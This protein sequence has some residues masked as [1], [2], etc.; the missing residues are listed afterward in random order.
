[1]HEDSMRFYDALPK[2]KAELVDG[3]MY[4]GGSLTKSVMALGYMVEQLGVL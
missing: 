3:Q 1:M 4:L 2:R